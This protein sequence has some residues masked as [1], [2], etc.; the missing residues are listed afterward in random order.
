MGKTNV[1]GGPIILRKFSHI[2]AH[3]CILP[4]V[5]IEEGSVVGAMSFVKNNTTSWMIYAGIPARPIKERSKNM[6]KLANP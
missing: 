5:T 3:C 6:I 1:S 4:N 2:A